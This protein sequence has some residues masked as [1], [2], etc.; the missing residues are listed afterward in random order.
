M[1]AGDN[2]SNLYATL[3]SIYELTINAFMR[4]MLTIARMNSIIY[5]IKKE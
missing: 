3:A 4:D 1:V 5:A 2:L